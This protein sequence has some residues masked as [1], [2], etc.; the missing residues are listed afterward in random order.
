M[1]LIKRPGQHEHEYKYFFI[2]VRGHPRIY[3]EDADA[4]ARAKAAAGRKE[5]R[6]FGVKWN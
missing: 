3:L 6:L 5:F 1:H 4:A 2:D